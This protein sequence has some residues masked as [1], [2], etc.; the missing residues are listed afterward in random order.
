MIGS[1]KFRTYFFWNM[2]MK[3]LLLLIMLCCFYIPT[4]TQEL[5]ETQKKPTYTNIAELV[6]RKG[7]LVEQTLCA[8]S[9]GLA[10]IDDIADDDRSSVLE[11]IQ[12]KNNTIKR[13]PKTISLFSKLQDLDIS[14]NQLTELPESLGCLKQLKRLN[15]EH[16]KIAILPK[17]LSNLTK[18]IFLLA[19]HNQLSSLPSLIGCEHLEMVELSHNRLT[20]LY[21]EKG[22]YLLP[23]TVWHLLTEGNALPDDKTPRGE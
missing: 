2:T 17:E 23:S 6:D 1:D 15:I 7:Y 10:A 4:A 3:K 20:T 11:I 16:N 14:Y 22:C 21:D 9:V 12:L 18:L 8:A 5:N 13:V 19:S